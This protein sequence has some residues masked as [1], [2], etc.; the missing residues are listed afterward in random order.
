VHWAPGFARWLPFTTCLRR[1]DYSKCA[2]AYWYRAFARADGSS[3]LRY[4][5]TR[6]YANGRYRITISLTSHTGKTGSRQTIVTVA[7]GAGGQVPY[8]RMNASPKPPSLAREADKIAAW[9][10]SLLPKLLGGD[11]SLMETIR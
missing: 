10:K 11:T 6:R 8:A 9:A 1:N 7:N 5:D 2:G 4:W 3:W